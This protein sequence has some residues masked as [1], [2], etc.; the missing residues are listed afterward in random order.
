MIGKASYYQM[1]ADREFHPFLNDGFEIR[2]TA[3]DKNNMV[4]IKGGVTFGYGTNM[5]IAGDRVFYHQTTEDG[6]TVGIAWR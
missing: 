6:K 5:N 4:Y 1:N 2:E 3:V